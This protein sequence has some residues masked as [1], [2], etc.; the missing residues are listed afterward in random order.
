MP[1]HVQTFI[2]LAYSLINQSKFNLL[3]ANQISFRQSLN[4]TSSKA[5][6]LVK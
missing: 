6:L 1:R 5:Q 4:Q 3:A 2:Y